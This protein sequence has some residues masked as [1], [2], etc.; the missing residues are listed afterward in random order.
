ML[1]ITNPIRIAKIAPAG[2]YGSGKHGSVQD[3]PI[4]EPWSL[5]FIDTDGDNVKS[6]HTTIPANFH[7]PISGHKSL[8]PI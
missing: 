6:N 1:T 5:L 8:S 3:P 7:P 2:P 4:V